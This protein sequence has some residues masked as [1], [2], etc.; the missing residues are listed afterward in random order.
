MPATTPTVRA[1]DVAALA[2]GVAVAAAPRVFGW[3][4][5]SA[6]CAPCDAATLPV[7]DRWA[8]H[9]PVPFW[10]T[11][12]WAVLGGLVIAGV[13]DVATRDGGGPYV[14]GMAEAAVWTTAATEV[15][16]TGVS[17]SR[18][19]MY[20]S[21]APEAARNADN[22]RSF[23]SGHTSAAFAVA[24]SYWLV[25]RDLA[26]SPGAAGWAAVGTAGLV[27]VL[28]VVAGKHFPSDVLAGALLGIAG[29][30]VVHAIKY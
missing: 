20:T 11:V 10:G 28:R 23:P 21:F 16:K 9:D 14:T 29:G 5:D 4:R 24:T 25:R 12:S 19:V 8:V 2:A 30:A 27:G 26:G 17:R 13:A 3:G 18:P 7:F 22:F 1:A 15:L 6:T